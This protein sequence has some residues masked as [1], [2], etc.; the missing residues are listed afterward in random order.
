[1]ACARWE[2]PYIVEWLLYHRAIGFD[3]VYLFCNDDDPTE[4][5]SQVL[6]LIQSADPFVT[7]RHFPFQGQ[8]FQMYMTGL[9]QWKDKTEWLM[10]LDIDEF[11]CI[12]GSNDI[13]FF[14]QGLPLD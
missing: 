12:R 11:L 6:P 4:L 5:Y 7:F 9:R 14:V 3:H 10:F 1:M 13:K 8:Q 2:T